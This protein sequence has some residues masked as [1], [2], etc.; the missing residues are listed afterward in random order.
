M[1][2]NIA[3]SQ[4]SLSVLEKAG[5][6]LFVLPEKQPTDLVMAEVLAARMKRKGTKYHELA[7][8]PLTADLPHGGLAAWVVLGNSSTFEQHT[9]LRKALSP[10]LEESPETLTIALC[11]PEQA[12]VHARKALYVALVNAV[13][14][15]NRKKKPSGKALKKIQWVGLAEKTDFSEVQASAAGNVL[16]R[17]LTVLPPNDLTPAIYREK[18]RALA[19]EN[20]WTHE[21]FD[22]KKLRKMG[23]GAF[24]AVAQGSEPEDAAIVHLTYTPKKSKNAPSPQPSYNSLSLRERAWGEG[25][26]FR[27]EGVRRVALVGKGICLPAATTSSPPATCMACMKT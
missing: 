7:K 2:K 3:I 14:L 22:L 6:V 20:G 24:V 13:Q 21:E 17:S 19:D 25:N 15:P 9:A 23:A 8:G 18:I 27:G 5:H 11:D 26:G 4:S 10:L 16:T 12:T 1:L